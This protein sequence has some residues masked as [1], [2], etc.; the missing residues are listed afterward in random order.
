VSDQEKPETAN[1]QGSPGFA[2]AVIGGACLGLMLLVLSRQGQGAIAILLV[3]IVGGGGIVTRMRI[4][5]VLVLMMIAIGTALREI[6]VLEPNWQAE[7]QSP[8][9]LHLLDILLAG[10]LLG[11]V[12][13]HYR[14]QGLDRH[15][16]PL[17]YRLAQRSIK[18]PVSPWQPKIERRR[19]VHLV[20]PLE[21]ILMLVQ[22]PLYAL[23]GGFAWLWLGQPRDVLRWDP[24]MV[25]LAI[26][27][28]TLVLGVSIVAALLK[29]WRQRHMSVEEAQLMMQDMLWRETR[30]E[31]R[32][33]TR[34]LAW[35]WI[36]ER[37][38]KE[39]RP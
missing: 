29:S 38:R 3:L 19:A 18:M 9:G 35:F 36:R 28:V 25:Q 15:I 22:L 31:Q 39:P 26:L 37:A 34:W 30:G 10:A 32:L 24:W 21:Q 16:F 6:S 11:Y 2:Y 14:L 5:P 8:P 4:A 20:T 27:I 1:P 33:L 7:H 17:D 23:V 13:S 12:V